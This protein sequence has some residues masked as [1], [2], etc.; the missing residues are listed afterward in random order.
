M[1]VR[2]KYETTTTGNG[3]TLSVTVPAGFGTESNAQ[4]QAPSAGNYVPYVLI[5]G[6]G[7]SWEYGY[8]SYSFG[9]VFAGDEWNRDLVFG[10]TSG[11]NTRIP[12]ST[13]T[14]HT[15]LFP[16]GGL[17]GRVATIR[18]TAS[19]V[20]VAAASTVTV[21]YTT[22]DTANSGAA[23]LPGTSLPPLSNQIIAPWEYIPY[24]QYV[25]ASLIV[26]CTAAATAG[27]FIQA[28]LSLLADSSPVAS[29]WIPTTTNTSGVIPTFGQCMSHALVGPNTQVK[30]GGNVSY[31][32]AQMY[33][34]LSNT[35]T[36]GSNT[37]VCNVEL[38][39]EYGF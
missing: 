24:A 23:S 39:L 25:R 7:S 17:L 32:P 35:D 8:G 21:S 11:D 9:T 15:I 28:K 1:G 37:Q 27:S 26:Q 3:T 30:I 16:E 29:C 14:P 33:T 19:S 31:N 22:I 34:R 5:D 12:L 6:N 10:G 2:S 4:I 36:N 38:I 13:T 20:N 18:Y